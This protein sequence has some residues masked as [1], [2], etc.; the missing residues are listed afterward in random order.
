MS[1]EIIWLARLLTADCKFFA[2]VY[3]LFIELILKLKLLYDHFIWSAQ[4]LRIENFVQELYLYFAELR[5]ELK[6]PKEQADR[7]SY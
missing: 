3:L 2:G 5:F 4:E 1:K 6:H 7:V